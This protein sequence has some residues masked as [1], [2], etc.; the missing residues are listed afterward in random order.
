V[1][2]GGGTS[3]ALFVHEMREKI[4][5]TL[6]L[7]CTIAAT[8]SFAQPSTTTANVTIK[9]NGAMT[10]TKLRDMD[11]GFVMQGVMSISVDPITGGAQTAYFT[12][13]A[14][15]NASATVS[16]SSTNLTSGAD[17]MPFT[18]SLAGGNSPNQNN[19]SIVSSGDAVTTSSTGTYYF[20]AGGTADLSPT[21]P[22]GTYSGD[23]ILSVAY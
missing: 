18:C 9:I 13:D 7:L 15:P 19:A 21:Q 17:N 3:L 1:L 8:E 4:L 16:F 11:M 14:G 10:L 20:W 6:V 2:P 22:L 23:F 5:T 12:F